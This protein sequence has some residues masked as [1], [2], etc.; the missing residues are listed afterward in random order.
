MAH[1][2]DVVRLK[3]GGKATIVYVYSTPGLYEVEIAYR[4][5]SFV[6]TI[7]EDDIAEVIH[8]APATTPP[9]SGGESG[10]DARAQGRGE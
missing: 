1:L 2:L 8:E 3:D 9:Q 4:G 10:Q 5:H 7:N 6:E